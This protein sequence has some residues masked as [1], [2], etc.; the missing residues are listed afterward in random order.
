MQGLGYTCMPHCSMCMHA[1]VFAGPRS[2]GPLSR[3]ILWLA[4]AA[5]ARMQA[6]SSIAIRPLTGAA[7]RLEQGCTVILCL[8]LPRPCN[9]QSRCRWG[10]QASTCQRCAPSWPR[11]WHRA[12]RKR[13]SPAAPPLP[14]PHRTHPEDPSGHECQGS[15]I[16][17][18][19]INCVPLQTMADVS[20]GGHTCA[21]CSCPA[22]G[23]TS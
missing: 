20:N 19:H 15:P 2:S 8:V 14:G 16:F 21:G 3:P 13:T 5:R 7:S 22:C 9:T 17:T 12:G 1:A 6:A 18:S 10:M 23:G 4:L 11:A